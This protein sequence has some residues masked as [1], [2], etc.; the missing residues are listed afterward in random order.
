MVCFHTLKYIL[1]FLSIAT[2]LTSAMTVSS[3]ESI[4]VLKKK[5]SS[6]Q[7]TVVR[8]NMASITLRSTNQSS[9]GVGTTFAYSTLA[10]VINGLLHLII[11]LSNLSDFVPKEYI[12]LKGIENAIFHVCQFMNIHLLCI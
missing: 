8:C 9:S 3:M 6:L 1:I 12:K 11:F 7:H 2:Q 4:H 5:L 10:L